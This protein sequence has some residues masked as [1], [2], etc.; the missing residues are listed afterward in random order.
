MRASSPHPLHLEV[1]RH[2]RD[3][4]AAVRIDEPRTER[5]EIPFHYREFASC[6]VGEINRHEANPALR[7]A[8][9]AARSLWW[10]WSAAA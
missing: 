7:E 5:R 6:I 4:R 2:G 3:P 8:V 9:R 1:E 10:A